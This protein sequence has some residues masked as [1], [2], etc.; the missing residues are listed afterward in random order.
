MLEITTL[1]III[2]VVIAIVLGT[3]IGIERTLANKTAGMR[4][5]AMVSLGSCIFIII[6]V[7]V[8][9]KFLNPSSI[10]IL[11]TSSAVITG[12]GFIGAGL[13]IAQNDKIIG[14]TTAAGLWVSA[15]VGM[16][17]GFGL[18]TLAIIATIASLFIFTFE[19]M[20]ENNIRKYSY[21]SSNDN[22]VVKVVEKKKV[23]ES[24]IK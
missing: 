3:I 22:E 6:S 9:S 4:T 21:E 23:E 7:M 15:G 1:D 10:N 24:E 14:L 20:L 13:M 11:A 5:Y 2:R 17:S 16:A 19:K 18:F 12:I 8:I